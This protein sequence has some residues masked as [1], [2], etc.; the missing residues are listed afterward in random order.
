MKSLASIIG[1]GES[2]IG[3]VP[4]K[5]NI[6]LCAE[7][8]VAALKDAGLNKSD[9]D[10]VLVNDSY[11]ESHARRVLQ[12]AEYFGIPVPQLK[13]VD[14]VHLGAVAVSGLMV[15]L[16][17]MLVQVGMCSNV[18]VV[19]GDNLL[20]GRGGRRNAITRMAMNRQAQF[21]NQYGP[22]TITQFALVAQRH[23]YEYGTTSE[24]LAAVAVALRKHASLHPKAQM[25][26]LITV[27]DVLSSRMI[28]SPLH[29]LDCSMISDSAWA[30]V[31]S[32]AQTAEVAGHKPVQVLGYGEGFSDGK[33]YVT[34]TV[35]TVASLTD[36]GGIAQASRRAMEMADVTHKDIDVL[37]CYDPFT[38]W[39][40]VNIEEI[41]FCKKGEGG[42]FVEGGRI[43]LG[44]ELPLNP[45][46]GL[47]SYCHSGVA[48]GGHMF[49][50]A[51]LQLRGQGAQ[52]QVK[53]AQ[54]ALV[55][56]YGS[57]VG[58]FPCTVLGS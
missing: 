33:G 48:G 15:H 55:Q 13:F 54:V 24:Q 53:D 23:M 56:G 44:G 57:Q 18:L 58:M 49:V 42:A 35:S 40:I 9:I 43:E 19:G 17:S 34:D 41:G 30:L 32:R 50:E 47:H 5:N 4:G 36:F 22:T 14:N 6:Q 51:A 12:F 46:G 11:V 16:A 27:E 7:A 26:D 25:R 3:S 20:T 39:P 52:R 29:L 45:H 2:E 38:I 21:E 31:V 37:F 8:A 1:V 10:G 28:S